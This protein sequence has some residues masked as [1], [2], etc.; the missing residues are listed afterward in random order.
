M[1][2]CSTSSAQGNANQTTLSTRGYGFGGRMIPRKCKVFSS[3]SSVWGGDKNPTLKLHLTPVK[4]TIIQI[5]K[6]KNVGKDMV[7]GITFIHCW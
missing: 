4:M 5:T 7:G 6:K 3:N 1:R 2:Q